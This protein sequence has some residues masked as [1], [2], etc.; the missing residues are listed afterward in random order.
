MNSW[1]ILL[2]IGNIA[3]DTLG[4]TAYKYAAIQSLTAK[5]TYPSR[6]QQLL[7]NKYL[8]LGLFSYAMVFLC[9]LAFISL[10]SLSMAI[11][12]AS[13]NIVTV[14]LAGHF[15]FHE[16]ITQLRIIGISLIMLGVIVIG[17]A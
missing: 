15:V 16:K 6:W 10:V 7:T 14:M 9:W 2:W 11:L 3:L 8:W 5:N 1:I 4:Q 12:L 17:L 13:A